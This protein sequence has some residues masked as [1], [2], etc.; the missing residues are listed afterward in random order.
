MSNPSGFRLEQ[1]M[2]A[3]QSARARIEHETDEDILAH[4]FTAEADVDSLLDGVIRA[5][6]ENDALADAAKARI[7]D[8]T[9]RRKRFEAR[10]DALRGVS[11]AVMDVLGETKRVRP[12]YTA[13]IGKPRAGIVI[14][15]DA[16]IPD[17]YVVTE[18]KIDRSKL[19]EDLKQGVVITGA[20][21]ANGMPVLI[22]KVK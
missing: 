6:L 8:L 14:T 22:L 12:D 5:A 1:A 18:R 7:E 19:S 11:F 10:R 13:S 4:L 9:A 3:L 20:E 16:A 21:L 2:S 15:D 17:E